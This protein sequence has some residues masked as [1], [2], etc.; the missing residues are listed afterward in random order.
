MAPQ[1]F[2][3]GPLADQVDNLQIGKS[4]MICEIAHQTIDNR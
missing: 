2:G 4:W 3:P 1:Q